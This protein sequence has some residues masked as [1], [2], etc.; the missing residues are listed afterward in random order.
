MVNPESGPFTLVEKVRLVI[1]I[2]RCFLVVRVRAG[3]EPLPRFVAAFGRPQGIT[4]RR[5]AP[6]RLSKAVAKSLRAGPWQTTC[7]VNAI[8]LYRLLREQGDPAELVIGLP[9]GAADH[10]GHAWVELDSIDLGPFLGQH[11]HV[12][13]ARF[14]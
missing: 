7:L 12:E 1:R 13:L 6:R 5:I 9:N 11:D 10:R 8:V 4:P 14:K 2:W 3:R